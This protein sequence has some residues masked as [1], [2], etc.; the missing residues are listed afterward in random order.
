[1]TKE[2]AMTI[3]SVTDR[4]PPVGFNLADA[5]TLILERCSARLAARRLRRKVRAELLAYSEKQL[6]ELGI[7]EADID[8]VAEDASHG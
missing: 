8:F 6:A 4:A 2:E 3:Q 1:L 5:V 7:R